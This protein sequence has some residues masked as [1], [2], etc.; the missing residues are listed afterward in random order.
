MTNRNSFAA[1]TFVDEL[2]RCGLSAVVIAP[3][4]RSTPLVMAFAANPA[5]RVYSV[6][7]ERS[8]GFFALGL[9]L[10]SDQPVALVCSSGTATANFYPAV[11]EAH[12]AQVPLLVLT[13]DRQHELR[14]SGANQTIDQVRLYGHHTLW[15]Y[16]AALPESDPPGV[17]VRN[18]RTLADRAYALANG[19]PKGAVHINFPFRKPLEPTPVASDRTDIEPDASAQPFTRFLPADLTLSAAQR[20]F[21][22]DVLAQ[23]RRGLI[24][25]GPRFPMNPAARAAFVQGVLQPLGF[26]TLA[27]VTSGLRFTPG[28]GTLSAY[29]TFLA[30]DVPF[31]APDTVLHFGAM[32]ASAALEAYLN[33]ITPRHRVLVSA[34][35]AWTDA[36]HRLTAIVQV[37]PLALVGAVSAPALDHDWAAQVRAADAAAWHALTPALDAAL[38]DGSAIAAAVDAALR[39]GLNPVIFAASSLPVRHL[40]QYVPQ[41]AH[42]ASIYSNRGASGIDGTI[43]S[44][45]GVAAA[46]A[47]RPVLLVTGDLAFYHDMNGLLA[48]K[49]GGLRNLVILLTNN[50]GGGI[51]HRLPVADFDPPFTEL[52]LTPHGLD[53]SHAA[54]MYGFAHRRPPSLNDVRADVDSALRSGTPSIIEVRTQSRQDYARREAVNAQVLAAAHHT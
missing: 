43:S 49:R 48:L 4:S 6:I 9:A 14:A 38:F 42:P 3:G 46:D 34:D 20:H 41:S 51:F 11:I 13:A 27:D 33:R 47:S 37:P 26:P 31:A 8:A 1:Q 36:Y 19:T 52:F 35:G 39:T 32:P 24:V 44:A 29:D 45:F 53:F 17:A 2:A 16:D 25:V 10:A 5:I 50:D 7:D 28:A 54:Q 40:E 23:T 21:L 30:G 18:L 22:R 12:Y 15:F